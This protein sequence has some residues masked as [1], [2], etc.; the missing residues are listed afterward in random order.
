MINTLGKLILIFILFGIFVFEGCYYDDFIPKGDAEYIGDVSFSDDILPI[1][2]KDCNVSGCHNSGGIKPDLSA[3][4]AFQSLTNGN[5]IDPA[6]PEESIVYQW[7][8]GNKATPMPVSGTNSEYNA[9]ML[10]WI[11]QGS[12][13]N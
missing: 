6:N 4:Q 13:N 9:K 5:Y 3:S 11:K 2:N 7:M 1:L 12:L 8:K 10:A